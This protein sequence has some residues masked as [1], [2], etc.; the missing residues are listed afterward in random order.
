MLVKNDQTGERNVLRL[1]R[2]EAEN[3]PNVSPIHVRMMALSF[4]RTHQKTGL[5]RNEH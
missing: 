4:T 3:V 2:L 5:T 1:Y